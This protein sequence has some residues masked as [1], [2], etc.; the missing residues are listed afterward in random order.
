MAK[1]YEELLAGATQIKNNE[2]PESNTHSLVGGQLVDMVEKQKEDSERIDNVS[3]SHKGYFQTLEQLK[4]KYPT[5]KEGETAWVGEPYPGNVYD[6][7][8]GA[9]HDTGVPANEGSGSG[10]SNYNDLEN[11]PSIGNVSLEGNKTLDELGIPSKQEVKEKQDAISQVNVTVN[12]AEGTPSGSASVSGSTLNINLENIK[13][14]PGEAGP[15]NTITIGTVTPSDSTDEASATFTGESP[16]QILNLVLPRG[17]QGNSGVSGS[18][19]DIVVINDLNG[20]ESEVGSVKVLAAEQGKVLDK[21]K[22]DIKDSEADFS[23]SDELGFNILEINK[24]HIRTKHFDSERTT[25]LEESTKND[26]D[27]SDENGNVLASFANGYFR[28]KKFDTEKSPYPENDYYDFSVV[29]EKGN[30]AVIV[31]EGHIRTKNFNSRDIEGLQRISLAR[32]S[33]LFGSPKKYVS[34]VT[35]S[36]GTSDVTANN[37]YNL[38]DSLCDSFPNLIQR[39]ED[40]GNS[41]LGGYAIRHYTIGLT[42]YMLSSQA[43]RNIQ[44]VNDFKE[45]MSMQK[46]VITTGVHGNERAACYGVYLA[47]KELLEKFGSEGWANFIISNSIIELIPC[48]NPYG[49]TNNI[50][51]NGVID[52]LNRDFITASQPETV[53]MQ[54]FLK[55]TNFKVAMDFHNSGNGYDYFVTKSTYKYYE[56][57]VQI[58]TMYASMMYNEYKE[59]YSNSQNNFPWYYCWN[60][61]TS[62]NQFHEYVNN[63]LGKL[64]VSIETDGAQNKQTCQY[65]K[66]QLIN[67]LQLFITLT[68]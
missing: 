13:G 64:G 26:L 57:Y 39:K 65:T 27:I 51:G 63:V 60:G 14:R 61:V 44:G 17:R 46:Y 10:T 41:A 33:I 28:T 7:V 22:P 25:S 24:G 47:I 50:A 49:I 43:D 21:K 62:S 20:G 66:N 32:K 19:A 5:P 38:Y 53:A 3:K 12:D 11:K 29:D 34:Q 4:A 59:R 30:S 15:S 35:A 23:I 45:S 56:L 2:L 8:G 58:S 31:H 67:Y 54:N 37:M 40:I 18:T 6:V 9:W 1:T 16:N 42:K 68:D 48:S 36:E 52:N 55:N